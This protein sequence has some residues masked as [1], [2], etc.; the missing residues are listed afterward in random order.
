MQLATLKGALG[1]I[2]E[3]INLSLAA[4]LYQYYQL[5]IDLE[6][7]LSCYKT[8]ITLVDRHILKLEWNDHI[9]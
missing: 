9:D 6:S 8:L 3:W 7:A 1:Q 4:D 5:I 2:A